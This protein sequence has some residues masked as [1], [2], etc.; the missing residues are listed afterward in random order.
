MTNL[1]CYS[2]ST[3]QTGDCRSSQQEEPWNAVAAGNRFHSLVWT[4]PPWRP[5]D[6]FI[7]NGLANALLN[8]KRGTTTAPDSQVSLLVNQTR[9]GKIQL[10]SPALPAKTVK[11]WPRRC[12]TRI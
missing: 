6:I 11:F 12:S 7:I 9:R 1:S 2:C 3:T 10:R 4:S 8:Q 5:L